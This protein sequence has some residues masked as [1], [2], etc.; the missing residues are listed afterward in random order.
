MDRRSFLRGSAV[1]LAAPLAASLPALA[2]HEVIDIRAEL[3]LRAEKDH[4]IV[5]M[6]RINMDEVKV[7]VDRMRVGDILTIRYNGEP[8]AT[9]EA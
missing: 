7:A 4:L 8:I 9:F 2:R 6:D 3:S 1:A 5:E